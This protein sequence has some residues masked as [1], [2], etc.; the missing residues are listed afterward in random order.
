M[1]AETTN[2]ILS[3]DGLK[4]HFPISSGFMNKTIGYVKAVD[5]VNFKI[6]EGETLGIVGESGCGKTTTGRAILRAVDPTDG[7]VLFRMKN[8][9]VVDTASVGNNLLD[10]VRQEMQIVFQDPFASLNPRLTVFDIVADPLRVNNI[11][12]GQELE[13]IVSEMLRTV[14]LSP[15]LSRRYPHAFSGGQR[16]RIGLAR[17]LIMNPRLVIADEPVSALDVS[18]QAQILNL[19]QDLQEDL[20]LTYLF[21]SHDLSVVQYICHRVAVMYVGK[22]VELSDTEEIFTSPKHPYTQA[23]LDSVPVPNPKISSGQA[24]LE[25]EIADPSNP[26]RGCYFHPRCAFAKDICKTEDPPFK[27]LDNGSYSRC[28]FAGEIDLPGVAAS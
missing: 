20:G 12:K 24:T 14:G 17:S 21:I 1:V 11:A 18:V 13:D 22:L 7:K 15:E 27:M 4:V 2:E 10:Q 5:D 8:G 28:H 19:M 25:G 16:Q 3:V 26:P 6:G 9:D 23:L